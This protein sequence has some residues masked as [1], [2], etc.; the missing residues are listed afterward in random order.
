MTCKACSFNLSYTSYL[1]CRGRLQNFLPAHLKG[2]KKKRYLKGHKAE[3]LF[4]SLAESDN[5]G[6]VFVGSMC[7]LVVA[8]KEDSLLFQL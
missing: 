7:C 4:V 3:I 1:V 8:E 2:K 5:V 6:R